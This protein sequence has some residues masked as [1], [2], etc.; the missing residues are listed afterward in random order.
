MVQ[1][2]ITDA[3]GLVG[4][5]VINALLSTLEASY[6][7][8]SLNDTT[9]L[10]GYHSKD[11]VQAAEKA[12]FRP[13]V[14]P[15]L[16]DWTDMTTW[17]AAIT[18]ADSVLLLTRFTS[19]KV[20]DVNNWLTVASKAANE[21]MSSD[22]QEQKIQPLHIVHVGVHT[23]ESAHSGEKPIHETWQQNAERIIQRTCEDN[24]ALSATF[25]RINFDGFNG[26]LRP[27]KIAYFLPK[28]T[29][30]GWMAREDIASFAAH[31]LL[32]PGNHVNKTYP[33]SAEAI[34][35]ED[36]AKTA[37]EVMGFK[38]Q[39]EELPVDSFKSM[40]LTAPDYPGYIEYIQSVADLFDGL[41]HDKFSWHKDTFPEVF[42]KVVSRRPQ[43]FEDWIKVSPM[44]QKLVPPS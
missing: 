35:L 16:I 20:T 44:A 7:Q 24:S 37:T 8:A 21:R 17:K 39:A 22:V 23:D 27:N 10:A 9:I 38:V 14:V 3:V 13:A 25:L 11:E 32:A 5:F 6:G 36:M 19:H 34:S 30:Y 33:L 4:A 12:N 42:E 43:R 40:A 18:N 2:L 1:I 41:F 28:S 31:I 26:L 15:T 29:R